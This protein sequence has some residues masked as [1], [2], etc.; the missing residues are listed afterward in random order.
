MIPGLEIRTRM[1]R[2]NVT[3]FL[4]QL[5]GLLFA[6]SA[7]RKR[8]AYQHRQRCTKHNIYI[9]IYMISCIYVMYVYVH[10]YIYIY[11]ER[12]RERRLC[13]SQQNGFLQPLR[14]S[15][16]GARPNQTI[17]YKQARAARR[18]LRIN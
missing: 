3:G 18:R 13:P 10:V 12:E 5:I 14:L 15:C 4:F 16:P 7:H 17:T 11:R 9:Y 6:S 1:E 8:G 2:H